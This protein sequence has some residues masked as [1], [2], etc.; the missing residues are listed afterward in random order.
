MKIV[1]TD[2]SLFTGRY[3]DALCG[4]LARRGHEVVLAG[5]PLRAT[6]AIEPDRYTYRPRFFRLS[7]GLHG[8]AKQVAKAAEYGADALTG[9]RRI[10]RGADVV[11][12]Q[13][14]PFAPADRHWLRRLRGHALVHTVHNARPF[15][16]NGGMQASGY[17][18]LLER[19]DHLI[20]HGEETRAALEARGIRVPISIV[21]HPPMALARADE[22]DMAAIPPSPR[23][24][25]L[26]FGTIKPYKG[27]DLLIEAA[28]ALWGEGADFDL[29]I[30]G[31]PFFPIEPLVDR[32]RAAGFGERLILDL[33]FLTEPRLDAHLRRADILAFPYRH[34]DSSGAFLSACHYGSAMVTSDSGMFARLPEGAASRFPAGDA[35]ALADALRPL[36]VDGGVRERAGQAA[37]AL[38]RT[39][40]SWDEAAALTEAAY[41]QAMEAHR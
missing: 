36:I 38:G 40:G 13:W 29:A 1:M 20:V 34:I 19:F 33:G 12:W 3:D 18:R 7:D 21:P 8:K 30:A 24:R 6:D 9:S 23:P 31:Q 5:R 16:G 27:I 15:H 39:L 28:L 17:F 4:G 11:H 25:L 32:I 35:G 41:A 26:F 22:A 10:F 2:P 37:L 14:L